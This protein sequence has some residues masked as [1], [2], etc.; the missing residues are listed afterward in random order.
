M[1]KSLEDTW[2]FLESKHSDVPRH[3]DGRP[4]IRDRMPIVY[5]EMRALAC[6]Y[7]RM[8]RPDH[9]LQATALVHEV[10]LRLADGGAVPWED[11]RHFFALASRTRACTVLMSAPD[12]ISRLAK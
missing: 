9:T 6:H 5:D 7:L 1:R 3:L 8:E 4:L 10:Y 12:A 11:R 2:R